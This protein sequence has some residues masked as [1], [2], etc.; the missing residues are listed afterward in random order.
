[1]TEHTRGPGLAKAQGDWAGWSLSHGD[2]FNDH[3]GPF[4][5]RTDETGAPVCAMQVEAKHLNGGGGLHGGAMATFADFCLFAFAGL[6]GNAAAVTVSLHCDYVGGAG[7]GDRIECRGHV[8]RE[9][10]SMIFLGGTIT[11]GS[12]PVMAFSGIL[13][14]LRSRP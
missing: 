11:H 13:K 2:P 5:Y 4:H 7:L 3:V 12:A 10:G 6:T 1:M 14:K 8:T 9:T